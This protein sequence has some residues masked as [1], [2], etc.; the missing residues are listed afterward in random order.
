M[1]KPQTIVFDQFA[2][3]ALRYLGMGE[4]PSAN[5]RTECPGWVDKPGCR[6][7]SD[8]ERR[9]CA[10]P[11]KQSIVDGIFAEEAVVGTGGNP[12]S[13]KIDGAAIC[14]VR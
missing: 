1:G 10:V 11:M 4:L 14:L 6:C 3:G 9:A 13:L 8:T 5:A 12:C 7:V 2:R